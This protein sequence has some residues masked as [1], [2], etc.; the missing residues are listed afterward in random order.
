[1]ERAIQTHLWIWQIRNLEEMERDE[2]FCCREEKKDI[3]CSEGQVV[4]RTS[5][6]GD[7]QS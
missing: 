4:M 1:M 5:G 6:S 2:K 7:S 3:E